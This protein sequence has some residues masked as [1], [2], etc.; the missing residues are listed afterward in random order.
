MVVV[1]A[2]DLSRSFCRGRGRMGGVEAP[3]KIPWPTIQVVRKRGK[4]E[5]VVI[6]VPVLPVLFLMWYGGALWYTAKV[7]L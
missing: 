5:E 1:V 6:E 4:T 7:L 2:A 3:V